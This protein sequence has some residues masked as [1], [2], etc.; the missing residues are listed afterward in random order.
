M[1]VSEKAPGKRCC[2][3][4]VL[5]IWAGGLGKPEEVQLCV[6]GAAGS[7]PTLAFGTVPTNGHFRQ[8]S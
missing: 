2:P 3:K 7:E 1:E 5:G 6:A 4:I 8:V